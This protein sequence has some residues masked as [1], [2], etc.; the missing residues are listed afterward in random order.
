[1]LNFFAL[2]F[3]QVEANYNPSDGYSIAIDAYSAGLEIGAHPEALIGLASVCYKAKRI[4]DSQSSIIQYTS[5]RT[6]NANAYNLA[7][8]CL[9]D[10][11]KSEF[12][13][14]YLNRGWD[15]VNKEGVD[16]SLR[17]ILAQNLLRAE[18]ETGE[19]EKRAEVWNA[20]PR[21]VQ[22]SLLEAKVRRVKLS[23]R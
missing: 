6:F 15:L 8:V 9:H 17:A 21:P 11:G 23:K 2:F 3:A 20:L 1:M 14:D 10:L 4:R 16:G 7:G 5:L 13:L 22:K 19:V 18:G 12:A